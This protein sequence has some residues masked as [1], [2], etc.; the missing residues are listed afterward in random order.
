M[1]TPADKLSLPE[2]DLLCDLG[3]SCKESD[4]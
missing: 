4:F 3:K 2:F 1:K